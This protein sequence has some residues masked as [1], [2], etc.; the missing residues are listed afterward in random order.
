MG[1]EVVEKVCKKRFLN[2]RAEYY[3]KWDGCSPKY[4]T[5]EP[6]ENLNCFALVADFE[7]KRASYVIGNVSSLFMHHHYNVTIL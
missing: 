2:G 4:N 1:E 7:K 3:L 6:M 5:W